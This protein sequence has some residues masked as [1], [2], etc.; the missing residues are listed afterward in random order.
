[1]IAS[2]VPVAKCLPSVPRQ[3]Q[4]PPGVNAVYPQWSAGQAVEGR[5]IGLLR[6]GKQSRIP[7]C[8]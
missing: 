2:L 1:M 6:F 3:V 7:L 8:N 5:Q 4:S